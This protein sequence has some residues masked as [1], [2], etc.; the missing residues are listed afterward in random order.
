MILSDKDAYNLISTRLS[1]KNISLTE[2]TILSDVI[3][4]MEDYS[5]V[6]NQTYPRPLH[7]NPTKRK[8]AY[9][10]LVA[11]IISLRTTLENEQKAVGLF[12]NKFDSINDVVNSSV[13]EIKNIISCAGMPI[14]KAN[15]ILN[16]TNYIIDNYSGDINKINN[17]NVTEIRNKLMSIP[18]IGDKSADCMLELGFN[19]PSIVVDTNV[20]RV[21]SRIFFKEDNLKFEKKEDIIKIK[22]FLEENIINDYRFFQIVH[23]IILLHGKN[24][25]K[26]N[27]KCE[28]CRLN[29]HCHYYSSKDINRQLQLF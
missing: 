29:T 9:F 3:S 27:P 26:S 14:K 7:P 11:I 5:F 19:L 13:E 2:K 22:K 25:C 28:K 4:L 18:G 15:M 16:I 12:L 1:E 10:T 8:D 20:F 6:N 21:I 17:G 24:I 23:T